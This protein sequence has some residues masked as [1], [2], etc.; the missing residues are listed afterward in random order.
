MA[1]GVIDRTYK[2]GQPQKQ[3][4]VVVASGWSVM[5][6]D[7]NLKKLWENKLQEDFPHNAHHREIAISIS[8]YTLKHGDIGTCHHW[9]ENG[10]A[11]TYLHGSF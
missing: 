9:R 2:Q 5:C 8:N 4:L 1:A 6:F 3:V 10:N 7:H 11:T